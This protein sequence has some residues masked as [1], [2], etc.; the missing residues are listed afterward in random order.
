MSFIRFN[1]DKKLFFRNNTWDEAIFNAINNPQYDEYGFFK[2]GDDRLQWSGDFID[3]GCHIGSVSR[4]F[5]SLGR[6]QHIYAIEADPS[7]YAISFMNLYE[8]ISL[9]KIS[10]LNKCIS[11]EAKPCCGQIPLPDNHNKINTGGGNWRHF[12]NQMT[13][14]VF[15]VDGIKIDSIIDMAQNPI[16]MKLDCEGCEHIILNECNNLDKVSRI[17]GEFHG[18]AQKFEQTLITVSN[19]WQYQYTIN[20]KQPTLGMFSLNRE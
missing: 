1:S 18:P 14:N 16:M 20:A 6:V 4:L 9:S 10:L 7:N 2:P 8:G 17:F 15:M 3:V 5:Y 13:K 12:T 19:K 11:I